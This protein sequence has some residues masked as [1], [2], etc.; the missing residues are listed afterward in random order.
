MSIDAVSGAYSRDVVY[1]Q[2]TSPFVPK[3]LNVKINAHTP[4]DK[5]QN[6]NGAVSLS[7]FVGDRLSTTLMDFYSD[8][9]DDYSFGIQSNLLNNDFIKTTEY[10]PKSTVSGFSASSLSS[11]DIVSGALKSGYSAQ[12]AMVISRAQNA[13]KNSVG[14]TNNPIKSFSTRSYRVS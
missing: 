8:K 3:Q 4:Y 11:K 14:I 1:G 2:L 10:P 13:Y 9:E 7:N 5:Q 12:Q 6:D